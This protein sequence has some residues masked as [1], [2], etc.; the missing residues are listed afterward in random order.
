MRCLSHVL[1]LLSVD[2]Q[3]VFSIIPP[4][5]I[6]NLNESF[7]HQMSMNDYRFVDAGLYLLGIYS[8]LGP[9]WLDDIDDICYAMGENSDICKYMKDVKVGPI[10]S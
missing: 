7:G 5:F 1:I 8:L 6:A 2:L 9:N 3:G 10:A 4:S